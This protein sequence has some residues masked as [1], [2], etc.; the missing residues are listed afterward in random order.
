MLIFDQL[1]SFWYHAEKINIRK[2]SDI[3]VLSCHFDQV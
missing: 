2:Q 3:T 1:L